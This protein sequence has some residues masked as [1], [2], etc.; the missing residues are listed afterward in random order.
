MEDGLVDIFSSSAGVYQ[1]DSVIKEMGQF[2][3][4]ALLFGDEFDG[5]HHIFF[6][7]SPTVE[8][9]KEVVDQVRFA[10]LLCALDF[11]P[12]ILLPLPPH[13]LLGGSLW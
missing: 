8:I 6:R 2:L 1:V 9:R 5:G 7:S 13:S 3:T 12:S 10:I 4:V 11:L